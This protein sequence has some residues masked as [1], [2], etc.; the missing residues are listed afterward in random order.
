MA[1]LVSLLLLDGESEGG[2]ERE[3]FMGCGVLECDGK[4]V[5]GAANHP[6]CVVGQFEDSVFLYLCNPG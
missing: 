3:G 2:G 6:Y 1:A 4:R 5:E